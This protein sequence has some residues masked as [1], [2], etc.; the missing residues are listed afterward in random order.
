MRAAPSVRTAARRS[1][2]CPLVCRAARALHGSVLLTHAAK[3]E[4]SNMS[5]RPWQA[6]NGPELRGSPL[7]TGSRR[8]D[9]R[10]ALAD[11]MPVLG[12][13]V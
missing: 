11:S 4:T 5:E 8:S 9:F 2:G 3:V 12:G 7:W 10:Q 13:H 6:C 1:R